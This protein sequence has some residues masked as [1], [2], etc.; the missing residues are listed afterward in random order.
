MNK[1]ELFYLNKS[2]KK[3]GTSWFTQW[4]QHKPIQLKESTN[5]IIQMNQTSRMPFTALQDSSAELIWLS[6]QFAN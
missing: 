1:N 6:F 2:D 4:N 3:T 5:Q